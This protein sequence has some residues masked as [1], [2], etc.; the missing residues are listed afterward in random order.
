[1][2]FWPNDPPVST[3]QPV[4][5]SSIAKAPSVKSRWSGYTNRV[6][7]HRSRGNLT[8]I[9]RRSFLEA[10]EPRD[11]CRLPDQKRPY[12]RRKRLAIELRPLHTFRNLRPKSV[13]FGQNSLL[14]NVLFPLI[15][16]PA[17]TRS[18]WGKQSRHA[19]SRYPY[20]VCGAKD[21]QF[22]HTENFP[23]RTYEM[24]E[25][26]VSVDSLAR[27]RSARSTSQRISLPMAPKYAQMRR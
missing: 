6:P 15:S 21:W 19:W 13:A 23:R 20:S 14:T 16:W 22:H 5:S 1:V 27:A 2:L 8:P 25:T 4:S 18:S 24:S 11:T 3:T 7:R 17:P 26:T 12:C 9:L 10:S